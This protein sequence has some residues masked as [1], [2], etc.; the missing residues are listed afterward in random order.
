MNIPP[1]SLFEF[2]GG[3]FGSDG[4]YIGKA[5]DGMMA[6]IIISNYIEK[7]GTTDKLGHKR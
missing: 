1:F 3:K 7:Q 2:V 5:V 6:D 4:G